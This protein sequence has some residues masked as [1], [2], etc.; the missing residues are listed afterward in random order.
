ML[1]FSAA[2]L[3]AA[4]ALAAA[5]AAFAQQPTAEEMKAATDRLRKND[6]TTQPQPTDAQAAKAQTPGQP[7]AASLP[8]GAGSVNETYGDWTVD[9]RVADSRKSCLL[10]Q[11][12]GDKQSGRRVFAIELRVPAEGK[13]EGAVLMP[14]GLKLDNGAILTLDDKDFGTGLRFSTCVPQ[15]CVLPVSFPA[16]ATDAMKKG[17]RLTVS[18]L[19]QSDGQVT[20]FSV[21]LNGF[22]A[23]L[24]R[25]AALG[26]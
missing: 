5:P 26:S 23:A 7:A 12:Q 8:N 9:C 15:G 22:S 18:S 11:A 6:R 20:S 17:Q 24:D 2:L 4:A 10:S 3:L 14:F 13:T 21:S 25:L 19:N 16:A 1:R